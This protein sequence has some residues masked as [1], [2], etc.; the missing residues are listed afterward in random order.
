ILFTVFL[1]FLIFPVGSGVTQKVTQDQPVVSRQVGEEV[2]LNCRYETSWN[3]YILFWYKQ[4]PSGEMTF[5]IRQES[6]GLNT[7]DGRY[8][9]NFQ[10]AQNF[11]SLTIS[12]LQLQD[13][14]KYFCALRELTVP[15]AIGEA[16]QKPQSSIQERPPAAGP[17]L[18]CT[19]ADPRQEVV[20]LWLLHLWSGQDY[21]LNKSSFHFLWKQVLE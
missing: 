9:T 16:E 13:S 8:S 21:F 18:K 14:A 6:K 15:E 20:V 1:C 2:T 17:K 7:K 12:A 5:L 4:P 19:P 10:K 3:E 11:I